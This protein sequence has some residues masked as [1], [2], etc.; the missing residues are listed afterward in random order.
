M[1]LQIEL[2]KLA[3]HIKAS[4]TFVQDMQD[5]LQQKVTGSLVNICSIPSNMIRL[6]SITKNIY[7]QKII[8]KNIYFQKIIQELFSVIV[9]RINKFVYFLDKSWWL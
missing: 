4:G 5:V 9:L 1:D 8:T 3:R 7:F 2:E 6:S